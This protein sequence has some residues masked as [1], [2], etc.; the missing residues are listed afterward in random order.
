VLSA[1]LFILSVT[2]NFANSCLLASTSE[3][4]PPP[5]SEEMI[6]ALDKQKLKE[7]DL[8]MVLNLFHKDVTTDY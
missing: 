2:Q 6:E 1:R 8:G 5:A 7:S 3:H 4:A